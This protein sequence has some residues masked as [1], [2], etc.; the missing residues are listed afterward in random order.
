MLRLDHLEYPLVT[1]TELLTILTFV[2]KGQ[3]LTHS[4]LGINEA[5]WNIL[6]FVIRRHLEN[7]LVTMTSLAQA[8]DVP[9][10]TAVRKIDQMLEE[11]LL[12]KRARTTTGKSF[13]LHPS[14][15]MLGRFH[16][17]ALGLKQMV[18][19]T[20]GFPVDAQGRGNYYFG[21]SYM[22]ANI[23]PA[24]TILR[25]GIGVKNTL[26]CL[27][28]DDQTFLVLKR[29]RNDLEQW[30]GGKV[31]IDCVPLDQ[32]RQLTLGD[33]RRL[34]SEYDVV[35]FDLPWMGE[36]AQK[37]LLVPLDELIGQSNMNPADFQPAGWEAARYNGV[38]YG[39]PI[40]PTPELLF[41]RKDVFESCGLEPP[42]TMKSML[43]TLRTL[44]AQQPDM[45]G[46]AFC[47]A[48]GTPI[49]HM[50]VQ[51]LGD[52]GRAPLDLP[53]VDG[54]FDLSQVETQHLTS[55]ID[56]PEGM[57]TA[58]YLLALR[59]FA[60]PDLLD[61]AWDETT[62]LYADGKVA[63][64]YIWSGRASRFE[65][66]LDSPAYKNSGYLPH[67]SGSGRECIAPMGGYA[68]GIPRNIA[69]ARVQMAWQVIRYL[70]SPE[71]IKF[72]VQNGCLV[73]PRFSVSADP[74][75]K[76]MSG[77][78]ETVDNL[79]QKGLLK[80]WQRPP[81]PRFSEMMEV[82]GEEMHRMMRGELTPREALS[83]SHKGINR[84]LKEAG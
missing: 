78:I 71:L 43:D 45:H 22:A 33:S 10:T 82:L 5:T 40:E 29:I 20:F 6:L 3:V 32:L 55:M 54:D 36:Y 34:V 75:V 81:V 8:A 77:I 48:R 42:R 41:Y 66:N 39:I 51:L 62:Q 69:P 52:F 1:K 65:L 27:F 35:D 2:E 46:I 26:R 61:M 44:K 7:K 15:D 49:A 63:M 56:T 23:I 67:P 18:A 74:E 76:T 25:E 83:R 47:A 24:P 28:N 16:E 31:E 64:A 59:E 12:I 14:E 72:Y 17:Y 84:L 79:A 68:L 11:E 9:Y 37:E 4:C 57:A 30:L 58:E 21:A 80:Y 53:K 13:S 50:F 19:Q 60:P 38:Q 70:T 73:S